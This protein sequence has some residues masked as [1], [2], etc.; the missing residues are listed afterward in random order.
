MRAAPRPHT[1][2][3]MRYDFRFNRLTHEW[4]AL[5]DIRRQ[6]KYV[7]DAREEVR[8]RSSFMLSFAHHTEFY[9]GPSEWKFVSRVHYQ[10]GAAPTLS[11]IL[12]VYF[13]NDYT[14]I[15][16]PVDIREISPQHPRNADG[17]MRFI[18][19]KRE[20]EGILGQFQTPTR[21]SSTYHP[22]ESLLLNPPPTIVFLSLHQRLHFVHAC[23]QGSPDKLQE[24]LERGEDVESTDHQ[25]NTGMHV[26]AAESMLPVM[27]FLLDNGANKEARN[28]NAS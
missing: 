8:A 24:R 19:C 4:E 25:G 2:E 13:I 18:Q 21:F 1:L 20:A 14:S 23:G 5:E 3:F 27:E 22:T 7:R 17:K 26:A 16:S 10:Y 15:L 12:R 6:G 28:K 9:G 11:S